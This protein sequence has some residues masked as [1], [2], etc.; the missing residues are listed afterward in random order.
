MKAVPRKFFIKDLQFNG[1]D[2]AAKFRA[3]M[4]DFRKVAAAVNG[5]I[6]LF[7]QDTFSGVLSGVTGSPAVSI[8][9][10]KVSGIVLL[11]L[12][13]TSGAASGTALSL[14]GLLPELTPLTTQKQLV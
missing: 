9:Y 10:M 4:D 12:P 1:Q 8:A 6:D 3:L 14:S 13:D 7:E 5:L 2:D 11:L